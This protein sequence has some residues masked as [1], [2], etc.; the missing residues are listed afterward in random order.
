MGDRFI[1]EELGC[2]QC[3]VKFQGVWP[4][5][6]TGCFGARVW[7][8]W[9][10]RIWRFTAPGPTAEVL[11]LNEGLTIRSGFGAK[12]IGG[13]EHDT[14]TGRLGPS[15]RSVVWSASRSGIVVPGN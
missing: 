13:D 2:K 8:T 5:I 11:R 9:R 14:S 10:S 3:A 15:R 4:L 7:P 6:S 12:E 1:S